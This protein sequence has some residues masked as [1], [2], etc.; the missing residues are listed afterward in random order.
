MSTNFQ[1]KPGNI[2]YSSSMSGSRGSR[3]KNQQTSRPSKTTPS[4]I[5]IHNMLV[6]TFQQTPMARVFKRYP[7]ASDWDWVAI[8][9]KKAP[10]V[11]VRASVSTKLSS[12]ICRMGEGLGA[13][14]TPPGIELTPNPEGLFQVRQTQEAF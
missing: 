14:S 6:Y 11:T 9:K 10:T 13:R 2:S 8:D 3:T 12:S 1:H 4:A 7:I 5:V